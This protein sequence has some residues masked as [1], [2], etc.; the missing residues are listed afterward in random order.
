[1]RVQS[2]LRGGAGLARLTSEDMDMNRMDNLTPSASL[3]PLSLRRGGRGVR[4][5][6]LFLIFS[7]LYAN[8][9]NP[10]GSYS[11]AVDIVVPPGTN[12]VQPKLS[13]AYNSNGANGILGVGWSLQGIP[14]LG[15]IN[16]GHGVNYDGHDTYAGP[17][18]KLVDISGSRTLF[19]T[20][21]ESYTNYVPA[22]G[23]CGAPANEP[24]SFTVKDASGLTMEF[25]VTENSRA[26]AIGRNWAVRIWALNKVSDSNGNFFTIQYA[27]DLVGGEIYPEKIIYT[28]SIHG[29][30]S[31]FRV[32]EFTYDTHR[33]DHYL[34]YPSGSPVETKWRMTGI[35]VRTNVL[36]WWGYQ[37]PFTGDLVRR[38]ALTYASGATTSRSILTSIQEFGSDNVSYLPA[39]TFTYRDGSSGLVANYNNAPIGYD[40]VFAGDCNGDGEADLMLVAL[41]VKVAGK[42]TGDWY[43]CYLSN[44]TVFSTQLA[45]QVETGFHPLIGD[46]NGD[47]KTDFAAYAENGKAYIIQSTGTAL[48]PY[49]QSN[50]PPGYNQIHAAGD[51]NGDGK[52]DLMMV[53]SNGDHTCLIS[54]GTQFVAQWY[55]GIGLGYQSVLGDFNGDGRMDFG[56]YHEHGF[57]YIILA[58][59]SSLTAYG[60]GNMPQINQPLVFAGDCNGD[61]KTD[62]M[63]SANRGISATYYN[64]L[65]SNGT[66][67]VAQYSTEIGF[68]YR[69]IVGDFNGDGK[70]DFAAYADSGHSYIISATGTGLIANYNPAPAGYTPFFAGD[71]NG[72]GLQDLMIVSTTGDSSQK[73]YHVC[74]LSNG[75]IFSN[76]ISVKIGEGYDTTIGSGPGKT[77]FLV[78]AH[79]GHSYSIKVPG[80]YPDLM[81]STG[82]GMGGGITLEYTPSTNHPGAI[83]VSAPDYPF[84]INNAPQL[85]VTRMT[86]TDGRDGSY[87]TTY[88]YHNNMR[89]NGTVDVRRSLGF[90]WVKTTRPDG[91]YG[92][93][94]FNQSNVDLAAMPM[95]E[96]QFDPNGQLV[97]EIT[98]T[99]TTMNPHPATKLTLVPQKRMVTYENGVA[100]FDSTTNTQYDSYGF[101]TVKTTTIAGFT[102]QVESLVYAHDLANNV[103]GRIT[104]KVL[105]SGSLG[106]AK[107]GHEKTI[108]NGNGAICAQ[109]TQITLICQKQVWLDKTKN[110]AADRF[111]TTSYTHT[112]YGTTASTTDALGHTMSFEYE[113]EYQTF[114]ARIINAKG[115]RTAYTYDARYGHKLT[116][117][118]ME[119]GV[120]AETEY[121][122]FGR[123]I[124]EKNVDGETVKTY[125]Y[126]N[127]GNANQ[128]YQETRTADNSSEGYQ[129]AR[130]YSDGLGRVYKK[131]GE[132]YGVTAAELQ[133]DITYDA[134]GRKASETNAYLN[135][136]GTPRITQYVYQS[137]GRLQ[138][139]IFPEDR[140]D[141]TGKV[142]IHYTYGVTTLAGQTVAFTTVTDAKGNAKTSYKNAQRQTV[143]IDEPGASVRHSYDGADDQR[144][145]ECHNHGV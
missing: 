61:G 57:A 87:P 58:T 47:G 6:I 52:A 133:T 59:G 62:L 27:Q 130:A 100:V 135:P 1:M 129:W 81:E 56:A 117:T 21:I 25:G 116:T 51:C 12:N 4:L 125:V 85:L 78:Y 41:R 73:G 28:Q 91:S 2:R 48:I 55:A 68:G 64:C 39:K 13:L 15:R 30:I 79:N 122:V 88:Q 106:G 89:Y 70:T 77:E 71:C 113:S 22:Y 83:L 44:G 23:T 102:P 54:N 33:T 35:I 34:S 94:Y 46:F 50:L 134:M 10:D 76:S 98:N 53:A 110:G 5:F 120:T 123:S 141:N 140:K 95:R 90:E 108:Y 114:P 9:V 119:N 118:D 49:P 103:L 3:L 115:Y 111:I 107:L 138:T 26:V 8:N 121:D 137:D 32:I 43:S 19:H 67:F 65:I 101:A 143:R 131:V 38:Y 97:S 136:G 96:T 20:E 40:R 37:V 63:I 11:T 124:Q 92:Y 145:R 86:T 109:P 36:D 127:L 142:K 24:C 16:N 17:A 72:D 60:Y 31:R 128:Q 139:T 132:G 82:N 66:Q 29:G 18:G 104:E 105:Y 45:V 80:R 75:T 7:P 126:A 112:I 69:T 93:V 99:M 14:M 84:A 144:R 74:Y 42:V